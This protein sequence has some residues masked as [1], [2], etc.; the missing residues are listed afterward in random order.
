MSYCPGARGSSPV[1]RLSVAVV[2][3]ADAEHVLD[4]DLSIPRFTQKEHFF[5]AS[6]GK[7]PADAAQ[8]T[9]RIRIESAYGW[10]CDDKANQDKNIHLFFLKRSCA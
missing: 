7:N 6:A 2:G 1:A 5:P 8:H 4:P 10:C 9:H 3:L